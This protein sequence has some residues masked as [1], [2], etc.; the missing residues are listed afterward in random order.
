MKATIW[1]ATTAT[2]NPT[3][4]WWVAAHPAAMICA[5]PVAYFPAVVAIAPRTRLTSCA[6]LRIRRGEDDLRNTSAG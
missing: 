2:T 3:G 5:V 1:P 6:G 4:P